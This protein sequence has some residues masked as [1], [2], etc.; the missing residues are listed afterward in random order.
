MEDK[1]EL[2][3][4]SKKLGLG[5]FFIISKQIENLKVEI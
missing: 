4:L 1:K 2:P 5:K 3:K